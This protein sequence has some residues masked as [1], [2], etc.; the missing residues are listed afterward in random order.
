M[1]LRNWRPVSQLK[2]KETLLTRAKIPVIDA[3]N[4]L[5]SVKD[6]GKLVADMDELNIQT[7]IN[8]DG[9]YANDGFYREQERFADAYPSR[10]GVL[11][12]IDITQIDAPD[13]GK[14]MDAHITACVNRGAC[15]IKFNKFMVG[16]KAK[17]ASGKYIKPDDPRLTPVWDCAARHNIP[18]LIHIADPV[19]FFTPTD[20]KNERFEELD[21][22]PSWSYYNAGTPSWDELIAAQENM[23]RANPQ[24]TYVIPHIG[25]NA[26]N[27]ANVGRM[28]DTYPNMYV[29]T[30]E[31][32]H[33]LGRQPY[34]AREFLIKYADRVIYGTDLVP[35]AHNTSYN[36]RFF[37]TQDEYFPYNTLE[38]HN[39]G[40]WMIYGVYLPDDALQKIYVD[41]AEQ[42]Y[43]GR[44]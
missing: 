38:E 30:A 33:E 28:L 19:A 37:E 44:K 39:Q 24:T 2:A 16:L 15:G 10:F 5:G 1:D 11:C 42:L 23:L 22:H 9:V 13:F 14:K 32:I 40:R 26:E 6:V 12:Q 4:H 20:E 29:D 25:S 17:D 18:I 3:H 7:I 35:N 41:N 8:L 43:F 27:L 34:T 36:Y 31:R 21:E